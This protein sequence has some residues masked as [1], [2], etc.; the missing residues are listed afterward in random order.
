L[1]KK[2]KKKNKFQTRYEQ[3]DQHRRT[4]QN[5]KAVSSYLENHE[6]PCKPVSEHKLHQKVFKNRTAGSM[7]TVQF[8]KTIQP[9]IV[10]LEKQLGFK[11]T[12]WISY[13]F[14]VIVCRG[15]VKQN[16]QGHRQEV[17][18][19]FSL[20]HEALRKEAEILFHL[21][22]TCSENC[23]FFPKI[24]F[25]TEL[26]LQAPSNNF[27]SP[28]ANDKT[29]SGD[30]TN[31]IPSVLFT[32][33]VGTTS[34]AQMFQP[35]VPNSTGETEW[36]IRNMATQLIFVLLYLRRSGVVSRDIKPSNLLWNR[37]FRVLYI[38]DFDLG[39]INPEWNVVDSACSVDYSVA[40]TAGFIRPQP[41]AHNK[42][43]EARCSIQ[44]TFRELY[45]N[46][47]FSSA[48]TIASLVAKVPE[49]KVHKFSFRQ[50]VNT[51]A[52]N[53]HPQNRN[54]FTELMSSMVRY[55]GSEEQLKKMLCSDFLCHQRSR[56]EI[57]SIQ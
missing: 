11:V 41:S 49:S 8:L 44:K 9:S 52:G 53:L 43:S 3:F 12:Q 38:C 56:F 24:L 7:S 46:D 36:D 37:D 20:C 5:T 4:M 35:G 17:C 29:T 18:A 50:L 26:L 25:F 54:A 6:I 34:V 40:G 31:F 45:Q 55:D 10:L 48:V 32:E 28:I 47:M 22:E 16:S 42:T 2:K 51:A 57:Q 15:S 33:W 14:P 1:S 23:H 19:K 27:N 13:N 30:R 21:E 39:E